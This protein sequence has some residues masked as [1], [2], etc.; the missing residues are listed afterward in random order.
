[1]KLA[2]SPEG[3][4]TEASSFF[5]K[6]HHTVQDLNKNREIS[7]IFSGNIKGDV[8]KFSGNMKALNWNTQNLASLSSGQHF[9]RQLWLTVRMHQNLDTSLLTGRGTCISLTLLSEKYWRNE[10]SRPTIEKKKSKWK[11]KT[12]QE[13]NWEDKRNITRLF[14]VWKGRSF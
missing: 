4:P 2:T 5:T 8:H 6:C 3:K 11:N 13:Q 12:D 9:H 1:M 7:Y 10:I 14:A